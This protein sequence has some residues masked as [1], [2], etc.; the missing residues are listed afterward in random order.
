MHHRLPHCAHI[1]CLVSQNIRQVLMNANGCHFFHM[2]EFSDTPLLRKHSQS[3]AILSD[4]SSAAIC[5]MATMRNVILVEGFNL[6]YH[7]MKTT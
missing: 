3:D 5:H 4:C 2:E 6:Y 7:T 1:H